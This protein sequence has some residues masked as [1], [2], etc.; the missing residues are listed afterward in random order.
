MSRASTLIVL[1]LTT[2]ALVAGAP[3]VASAQAKADAQAQWQEAVA[4][5]T[6]YLVTKGQEQDGAYSSRTGIGITALVTTSLMST[7][8]SPR[9]PAIEKSLKLLE[10]H[11][12][13]DGGIYKPGSR[14]MNYETCLALVCFQKA[15]SDGKYD[16]IIKNAEKFV[17]GLNDVT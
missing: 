1:G 3:S 15:N 7:G 2:F 4:R 5:G 17:R 11:V 8:R 10:A 14:L 12:Q 13:P 9:E 16:T 6:Q